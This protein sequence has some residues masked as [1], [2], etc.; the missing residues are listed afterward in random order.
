MSVTE[1][2]PPTLPGEIGV[3][4]TLITQFAPAARVARQ[5]LVW[6]KLEVASILAMLSEAVPELVSVT[7]WG[8]GW[9]LL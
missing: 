9:G 1:S 3:K 5:L 4:V 2:V 7:D 6:V 8:V